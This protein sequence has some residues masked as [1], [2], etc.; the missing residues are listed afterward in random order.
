MN[1]HG[2]TALV[3]GASGGIGEAIARDL[4]ARGATVG[5][6]GT[7]AEKLQ[8]LAL[9]LGNARVHIFPCNLS[10]REAVKQLARQAEETMGQVD[11]LVNNAGI[12]KDGLAM[13][14]SDEDWD[15]V[16][17]VNLTA[18]FTLMRAVLR[19][20]MKHRW[21]RIINISSVVGTAGN[22]G[23]ANYVAAKAGM[24]GMGKAVAMEVASRGITVNS[25]AP[26][27]I[28]TPMTDKLNAEQQARITATIPSGTFGLPEDVAAAV[29]FLAS[30][31]ARY[32]TG[33][34]LH[35]N[36]GMLMV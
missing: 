28:K 24:N 31:S 2:K 3:T 33:Q 22:P 14:M 16:L 30:D 32:I 27:F 20:M 34:T 36:G 5:I 18:A 8:E 25:V 7:K 35:V 11:I 6:S 1:F 29:T 9:A 10:D 21:G 19:G 12:T 23:Q 15:E 17:N 26:G 13:R 4:H